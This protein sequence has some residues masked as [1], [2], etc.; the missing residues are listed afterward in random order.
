MTTSH[1]ELQGLTIRQF[2]GTS[3]LEK[4]L[5]DDSARFLAS[6]MREEV[7]HMDWR[8]RK[9]G[10]PLLHDT[11]AG[12]VRWYLSLTPEARDAEQQR[13]GLTE[14]QLLGRD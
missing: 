14:D 4:P 8:E 1:E 7:R 13:Y 11:G 10:E 12:Y 5:T 2:Y 3:E 6:W 9:C